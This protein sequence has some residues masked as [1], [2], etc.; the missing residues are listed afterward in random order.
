MD[1]GADF[2][3]ILSPLLVLLGYDAR[4]VVPAILV[5]ETISGVWGGSWHAWYKN[6]NWR[7]V[8][9]TLIGS[10][11]AMALATYV[12][13]RYLSPATLKYVISVFAIIMGVFVV[14][15]SFMLYKRIE[16]MNFS[17]HP[18]LCILMGFLIGYQK[19]TCY[20]DETEVLRKTGWQLFKGLSPTDEVACL[21]AKHEFYWHKPTAI[22]RFAYKGKMIRIEHGTVDLLVTPNH[23]M[24]V[25]EQNSKRY[26][27]IEASKLNNYAYRTLNR[28]NWG[29]QEQEFFYLPKVSYSDQSHGQHV[30]KEKIRMDHWLH[31]LGW[32]V[33]E[34]SA[35][36]TNR[37]YIVCLQQKKKI[38]IP[39]IKECLNN[40]GYKYCYNDKTGHFRIYNKQL[41]QYLAQIGKANDKQIPTEFLNVSHRQLQILF[42]SL[43]KGDGHVAIDKISFYSSS[44]K[45]ADQVQEICIKLGRNASIKS[46]DRRGE[47]HIIRGKPA[48][49]KSIAYEVAI[50]RSKETFI[51][52]K[53]AIKEQQYNGNVYC[54][55]VPEHVMLV[56]RKG[57][58]TWS[59]NS[60]GN[61]GP[62]SVTGYMVMG[63]TAAV[64]IGTTTVAEG[65][66][67]ALGVA[68]YAEMTGIVLAVAAPLA[69]GAFIADPISA[70]INNH[71][72]HKLTPPFHGR[73]VGLAM[74]LVGAIALLKTFGII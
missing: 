27:M 22:Q 71:L 37:D 13:G 58:S 8:G 23:N 24:Y 52:T 15:R 56:R 51:V 64:A 36:R 1:S 18:W 14:A 2:G 12:M 63:M 40:L 57:Y 7:A 16:K 46:R 10:L 60:G 30:E 6:V 55:T 54:C 35:V 47:S 19:G 49:T 29:G 43:M 67:C 3:T 53:E 20:D 48:E 62:F 28:V 41:Y 34:G 59:C 65:I 33:S 70:W 42:D 5:S 4:I 39:E 45:L 21:S 50:R 38:N 73:V 74:V 66:A 72:K 44:K 68:M 26:K 61:Y 32:Y 31:F 11:V 25:R 69:I 9:M 17:K